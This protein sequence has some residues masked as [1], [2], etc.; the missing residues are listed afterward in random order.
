[1]NSKCLSEKLKDNALVN[2]YFHFAIF[3]SVVLRCK[4]CTCALDVSMNS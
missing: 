1:M 2:S 4:L 3:S